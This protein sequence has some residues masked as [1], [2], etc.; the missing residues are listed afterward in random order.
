MLLQR[1]REYAE[2][3]RVENLAPTGYKETPIRY[4]ITLDAAGHILGC[5]DQAQGGQ[6]REK[7]GKLTIA[8]HIGRAYAIRPKLLSDNGEYALGIARDPAKQSRVDDSHRA[9][10]DLTR[11]C[12]V[13]TNEIAVNAVLAFLEAGANT[14]EQL[15]PDF[16]PSAVVTFAVVSEGCDILPFSLPSVRAFW[17]DRSG[18][19]GVEGQEK[20]GEKPNALSSNR[21]SALFAD[22]FDLLFSVS[23]ISG[24]V[25]LVDRQQ[26]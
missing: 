23:L 16:D 12:A 20:E 4:L 10:I 3:G 24:K 15:P 26:G 7:R 1:L 18:G 5:V 11:L 19:D 8:P 17:A 9:F 25:S 6:G 22:K 14:E 13:A 2:S 21:S